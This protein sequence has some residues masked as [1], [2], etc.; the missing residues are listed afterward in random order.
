MI[1]QIVWIYNVQHTIKDKEVHNKRRQWEQELAEII[2]SR[3]KLTDA[4][5]VQ[6]VNHKL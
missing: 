3:N 4:L 6:T 2:K 1:A 5:D